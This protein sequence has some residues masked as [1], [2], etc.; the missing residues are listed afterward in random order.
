MRKVNL[1]KELLLN[2][3][4]I[5]VLSIG[6]FS[7]GQGIGSFGSTS[8]GSSSTSITS[9]PLVSSF[10]TYLYS[11]TSNVDVPTITVYID[12]QPVTLIA[13]TGAS[14][15]LV[16]SSAVSIPSSDFTSYSFSGQFGDGS[17]FSGTIASA[18]VCINP[19]NTTTCVVMPIGVKFAGTS[20]T[21]S[22]EAQGD[23]GLDSGF[24]SMVIGYDGYFS[25]TT[26]Y[27]YLTYLAQQSSINSY[28]LS[29]YPLSNTFYSNVSAT[30]PI[31][32]ITFGVYNGNSNTLVPYTIDLFTGLPD[33]SGTFASV[34]SS[35]INN[36][37]FD[38][39]S[40][41]NF[42]STGAL[43]TEIPNFSQTASE[44][45]CANYGWPN[46][47]VN[48]GFVISYTLQNYSNNYSTSFTTE[49]SLSFC[50]NN[51]IPNIIIG[52]TIDN[53]SGVFGLEDF[54]LPEMLRHTF[55]WVLGNDGFVQYIGIS[56]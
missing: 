48:G 16:N 9:P 19:S 1:T 4:V 44:G 23:F 39:G 10:S 17:T 6:L 45:A 40:N 42:L 22:G 3:L 38:T 13:D 43:K 37:I 35:Y 18:T 24:N 2:G 53:G 46:G 36:V 41:F 15:V 8:N 56:P 33:T 32:E 5:G 29:F 50:Q 34:T 31:G 25:S 54:G 47:I 14:G 20:F 26:G 27:S 52:N 21:S 49:P 30:T 51:P 7:C 11:D 55:T 28:T 12:G